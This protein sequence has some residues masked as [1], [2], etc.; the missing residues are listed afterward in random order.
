MIKALLK[1]EIKTNVVEKIPDYLIRD[2]INGQF[3][4][5]KGYKEVLK[6]EKTFEHIMGAST[7]QAMLVQVLMKFLF[8]NI[9]TKRYW[10]LTNEV[11]G[12]LKKGLNLSFDIAVFDKKIL[13]IDK[14][15]E[16]YADVPP[17]AVI[18]IDVKIEIENQSSIDYISTKTDTLLEYGTE[19]II[20]VLTKNKKLIVARPNSE[21]QIISWN[22]DVEFLEEKILNLGFLLKEEGLE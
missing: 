21:W 12:H 18:E 14:I 6:K 3:F 22:K 1:E 4:Y 13:T 20:W 2:E 15:N 5:Y 11:G 8:D 17:K 7:L 9:G 19:L 10:F 16:Y